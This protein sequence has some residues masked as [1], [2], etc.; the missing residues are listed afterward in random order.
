M[1]EPTAELARSLFTRESAR[2]IED[3]AVATLVRFGMGPL[4]YARDAAIRVVL[5]TRGESYAHASGALMRLGIDVD[6]WPCPPAGLFVVEERTVYLRSRSPMTVA[7]EFAHALDCALGCGVYRSGVDPR[8][9]TLFGNAPAFVTPYAATGVDEYF[10][11]SVRAYVEINDPASPWPRATRRRLLRV[12]PEMYDYVA[13][14]FRT[15]FSIA[16]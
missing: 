6:A 2:P 3:D 7:H 16:A 8:V 10:A 15:E 9:R 11:E 1:H 5:L 12:D 4:A 14:I 13:T